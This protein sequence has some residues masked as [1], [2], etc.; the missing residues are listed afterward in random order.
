MYCYLRYRSWSSSAAILLSIA[1]GAIATPAFAQSIPRNVRIVAAGSGGGV[2]SIRV[3]PDTAQLAP[4]DVMRFS[5]VVSG[6][7]GN[8]VWT[9]TGGTIATDG[10]YTAGVLSGTYYV[11]ATIPGVAASSAVVTISGSPVV[12]IMPGQNIQS[13]VNSY[14]AGTTFLLKAGV[15][16]NQTITPRTGDSFVGEMSGSTRLA[17]L[18]GA[19]VLT[20]WVY[21]GARWY[22]SGQNQG[23]P[24]VT[25]GADACLPTLPRFCNAVDLFFDNVMKYHED[26]LSEVG[27]V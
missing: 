9:A 23:T 12:T 27:P 13:V 19:R 17:T 21:D 4:G 15:H 3:S 25:S 6:A 14:P 10:S 26:V 1:A 8:V 18:S 2:P 7:S 11:M 20:G 16:R 22:V 5:P 24:P